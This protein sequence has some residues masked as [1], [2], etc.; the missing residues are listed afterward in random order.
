MTLVW[1]CTFHKVQGLTLLISTVASL[2]LIEQRSFSPRQIYVALSRSMSLSKLDILSDFD[3]KSIKPN[4][5]ALE[6]YEYLRKE[7]NLFAQRSSLKKPI[8]C[9]FKYTWISNK[10]FR[11]HW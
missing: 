5:L 2:E 11:F 6:H 3:P 7:K 9:T 8:Y 10:Y 4:H 1:T